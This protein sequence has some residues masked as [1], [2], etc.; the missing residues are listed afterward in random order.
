MHKHKN[1]YTCN[2]CQEEC[3]ESCRGDAL[4]KDCKLP[5]CVDCMKRYNFT[6]RCLPCHKEFTKP[7]KAR[8]GQWD[9]PISQLMWER[10]GNKGIAPPGP[11]TRV[12]WLREMRANGIAR[13][14]REWEEEYRTLKKCEDCQRED[15]DHEF[16]KQ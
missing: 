8:P 1:P 10:F 11:Q 9:G 6:W 12:E 3:C 14:G 4:C 13:E 15:C 5:F 2:L 16:N 7:G